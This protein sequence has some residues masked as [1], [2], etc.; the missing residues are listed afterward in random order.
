MLVKRTGTANTKSAW[1]PTK[2]ELA[3][4]ES[5]CRVVRVWRTDPNFSLTLEEWGNGVKKPWLADT[6]ETEDTPQVVIDRVVSKKT[7][8]EYEF[9]K[10]LVETADGRQTLLD[11]KKK[12]C[13]F[14]EGD[15]LS[16][17]SLVI[18]KETLPG[19]VPHFYV[20]GDLR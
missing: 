2:E 4:A 1:V 5:S 12:D 3:G 14:D 20:E 7:G 9:L 13:G 18:R 15:I 11:T 6:I 16:L 17:E 19:E 8:E 10:V